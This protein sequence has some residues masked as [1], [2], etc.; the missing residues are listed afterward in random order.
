MRV[1]ACTTDAEIFEFLTGANMKKMTKQEFNELKGKS[2]P[3]LKKRGF[4]VWDEVKGGVLIL[5]PGKMYD[6]IPNGVTLIDINEKKM[7]FRSGKSDNDV[8]F[9]C[10]AYGFIK[11]NK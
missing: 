10:L 6:Q 4:R 7:V 8:R 2:I 11:K 9:G 3:L 5:I 1:T